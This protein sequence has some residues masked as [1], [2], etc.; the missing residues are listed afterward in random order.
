M[1]LLMHACC[2]PCSNAPLRQVREEG[3]E[4]SVFWYN[5]NIH[6]YQ[7]YKSRKNS[8]IDFCNDQK[9]DLI[10]EDEY[11]LKPFVKAVASNL[12][13]RCVYCYQVRLERSAIVAKEQGFD[14]FTTSL[15]ISPYQNHDL[16]RAVG[17]KMG[18]K[19]GVDFYYQDFRPLFRPSQDYARQAEYYMQKYCGCIF[20]EEDRYL[21]PK[22]KKAKKKAEDSAT[23]Q[24]A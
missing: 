2:A 8:L 22:V 1:K 15:L 16:L 10:L 3:I 6:P 7:E 14:A 19:Y 12:E 4:T 11:G 24:T 5:P 13:G 18:E 21:K 17:E 9:F 20:S 23:Q